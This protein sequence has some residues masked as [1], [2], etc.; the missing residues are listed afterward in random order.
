MNAN[1]LN[2]EAVKKSVNWQVLEKEI[3]I[4]GSTAIREWKSENGK[5]IISCGSVPQVDWD[6]K[7]APGPKYTE[8]PGIGFLFASNGSVEV[9][10]VKYYAK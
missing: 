7:T 3:S 9:D 2:Y 1:A 10:G 6:G 8:F 5:V 4:P